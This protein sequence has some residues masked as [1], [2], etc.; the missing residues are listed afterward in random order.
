MWW[1][2]LKFIVKWK[3]WRSIKSSDS[4]WIML[5]TS[6]LRVGYTRRIWYEGLPRKE[7]FREETIVNCAMCCLVGIW[8]NFYKLDSEMLYRLLGMSRRVWVLRVLSSRYS[9]IVCKTLS[10]FEINIKDRVCEYMYVW[11]LQFYFA[12]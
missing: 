3:H 11:F 10:C 9:T 4:S 7:W 12:L 1:L 2:I 8:N 5:W 6:K